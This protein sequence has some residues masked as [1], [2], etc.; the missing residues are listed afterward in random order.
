MI[1]SDS[2]LFLVWFRPIK[3]HHLQYCI[4][5]V[6][7][8]WYN[9]L[10]KTTPNLSPNAITP[11]VKILSFA[12]D[13]ILAIKPSPKCALGEQVPA[14]W[15]RN[16]DI[17]AKCIGFHELYTGTD[18]TMWH[19]CHNKGW[20]LYNFRYKRNRDYIP[21]F[22]LAVHLRDCYISMMAIFISIIYKPTS[23]LIKWEHVIYS[24]G[25]PTIK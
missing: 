3:I 18:V 2:V 24:A 19:W 15:M 7:V 12:F 8:E 20:V 25:M 1:T 6:Q 22:M 5:V 17:V 10:Q 4:V 16:W 14:V 21:N 23:Q 13:D 9:V 11:E